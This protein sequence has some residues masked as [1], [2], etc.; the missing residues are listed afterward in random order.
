MLNDGIYA[1]GEI[2]VKVDVVGFNYYMD[3]RILKMCLF[4]NPP[5]CS[6]LI[7]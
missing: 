5:V 4:L 3:E 7:D 6:F 1:S 2:P